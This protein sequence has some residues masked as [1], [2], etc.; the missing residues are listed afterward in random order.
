MKPVV[1]VQHE[2]SVPPGS[3]TDVLAEDAI[4]HRVFEA[5]HGSAWPKASEIRALV[6]MGGTMNVDQ[7]DRYPML[8]EGRRLMSDALEQGIPTLGVCLGSQMMA[9]VLGADVYRSEPRNATFSGL[10]LTSEGAGDLLLAPFASGLPVLQFH[11]DTFRVPEL[12]VALAT[13]DS[14]GLAQAFRYGDNTYAIQFHFEVDGP[15]LEGWIREIGADSLWHEWGVGEADLGRQAD[16]HIVAQQ[17]AGKELLRRF[18]D[19]AL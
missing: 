17:S 1:I 19:H 15:I 6:V 5:W 16:E 11:E 2:A 12:A 9:R 10:K 14:S 4:D 3:I 8:A 13:S 7:L 18:L